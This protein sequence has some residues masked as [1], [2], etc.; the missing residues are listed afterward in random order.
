MTDDAIGIEQLYDYGER[1]NEAKDK[2]Q[3][4]KDYRSIIKATDERNNIKTKQLAAQLISRFFKF[5]SELS[6][7]AVDSQIDL[8][9]TEDL[10]ISAFTS[11]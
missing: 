7:L 6:D 11:T 9:E 1:L 5:F 3:H 4:V 2:S 8:C 10:G